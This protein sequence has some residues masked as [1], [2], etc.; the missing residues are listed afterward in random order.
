M[1]VLAIASSALT[2]GALFLSGM[3]SMW[4][5]GFL[6]GSAISIPLA[7]GVRHRWIKRTAITLCGGGAFLSAA[8]LLGALPGTL[9]FPIRVALAGAANALVLGT[10]VRAVLLVWREPV[11]LLSGVLLSAAGGLASGLIID[12]LPSGNNVWA[13]KI[14]LAL[15]VY[16]VALA[17]GLAHVAWIRRGRASSPQIVSPEAR[18]KGDDAGC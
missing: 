1:I 18:E 17:L 11:R 6:F 13:S 8:V 4:M 10:A 9:P 14:A 3:G 2:V 16:N 15:A 7:A 12:S 5:P